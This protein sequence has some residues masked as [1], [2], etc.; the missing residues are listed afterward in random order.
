LV[1]ISIGLLAGAVLS[2]AANQWFAQ[3]LYGVSSY[4]PLTLAGASVIFLLS[5]RESATSTS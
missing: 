5:C 4:D 3:L 1:P 2:I